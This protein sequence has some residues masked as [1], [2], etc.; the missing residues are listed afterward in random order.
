MTKNICFLSM[1]S[2]G[3]F[4]MDDHLAIPPL[5]K[6][7]WEVDTASWNHK[8]QAWNAYDAVIIRSTWDYQNNPEDFLSVL[9]HIETQTRLENPSKIVAWNLSKK[10]YLPE[11]RAKG[12]PIVPTLFQEDV[13]TKELFESWLLHFGCDE[14][15]IKPV[16]SATAGHTYRL[17]QF[18]PEL[19]TI[20][21]GHDRSYM[22]Q[23]FVPNI[24]T[25][26][27]YSLFYFG[28]NFSHAMLKTP[29]QGDF[30]VQEDFGGLNQYIKPTPEMLDFGVNALE[31]VGQKLLYARVDFV[32]DEQGQFKLMEL[33]LIEPSMYLRVDKGAP[34]RFANAIHEWLAQT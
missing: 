24:V 15:I 22:V 17:K 13:V 23:P 30:R 9:R 14:L 26:G 7:G 2:G 20:F 6:L 21:N 18:A 12:V 32:K 25:E 4:E 1:D 28:G 34:Q 33:E 3:D 11:L 10:I 8:D 5:E 29:K 19:A 16:I 27:E 31:K